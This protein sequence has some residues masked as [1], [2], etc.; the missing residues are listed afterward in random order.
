MLGVALGLAKQ[1]AEK[2]SVL[3]MLGNLPCKESLE[4]AEAAQ[5]DE[6]V[7]KEAKAA[8]DRIAGALKFQ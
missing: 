4:I 1:P 5:R 7:A 3:S 6:A 8:M 2:R